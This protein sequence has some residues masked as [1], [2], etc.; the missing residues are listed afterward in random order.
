MKWLSWIHY[1]RTGSIKIWKPVPYNLHVRSG[2][3]HVWEPNRNVTS[4]TEHP[5]YIFYDNSAHNIYVIKNRKK[6]RSKNET[7]KITSSNGQSSIKLRSFAYRRFN[8]RSYNSWRSQYRPIKI[9]RP[10]MMLKGYWFELS[11]KSGVTPPFLNA[12]SALAPKRNWAIHKPFGNRTPIYSLNVKYCLCLRFD[13]GAPFTLVSEKRY[14]I[15]FI[16]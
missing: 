5:N 11:H 8:C 15:F 9:D 3:C 14:T 13:W 12:S 7:M 10:S 6:N 2:H 1:C 4:P 16:R